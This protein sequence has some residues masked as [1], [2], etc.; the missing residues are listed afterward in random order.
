MSELPP[1]KLRTE[2]VIALAEEVARQPLPLR[3]RILL[4]AILLVLGV[5]AFWFGLRDNGSGNGNDPAP[6]SPA[7]ITTIGE[8]PT[9]VVFTAPP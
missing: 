8:I 1:P 5:G 2:K 3:T 4:P 9:S 7:E 6:P